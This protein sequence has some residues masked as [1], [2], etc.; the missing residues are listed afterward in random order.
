MDAPKFL[1]R[2]HNFILFFRFLGLRTR[3]GNLLIFILLLL[4]PPLSPSHPTQPTGLITRFGRVVFSRA[5]SRARTLSVDRWGRIDEE[6]AP[7]S[8]ARGSG[9][10]PRRREQKARTTYSVQ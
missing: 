5:G 3:E 7:S 8:R 9:I 4:K 1:V 6:R 2:R 10:S